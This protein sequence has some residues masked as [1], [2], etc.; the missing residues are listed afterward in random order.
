MSW[1]PYPQEIGFGMIA[2]ASEVAIIITKNTFKK[3]LN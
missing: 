3:F 1:A 2:R